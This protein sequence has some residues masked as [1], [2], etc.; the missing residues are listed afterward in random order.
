MTDNQTGVLPLVTAVDRIVI[1]VKN[2]DKAEAAYTRMFGRQPSWRRRDRAGGTGHVYYYLGNMGVELAAAIG[3]GV[4]GLHIEA[5]LA[6]H[7]EGISALALASD[8][9]ERTALLLNDAG[10]ATVVMPENEGAGEDG[11]IR[12]WRH[13]LIARDK[14]R[15]MTIFVCQNYKGQNQRPLAPLRHGVSE[16]AAIAAMDHVVVMTND[17]EACKTLFG[18]KFGIRLALDHSKPEWGVR[19]LFFRLGG[20]T[21][22]VVES[23]DK[24]KA[25]K[26]DFLWGTAWKCTDINA[27][28]A[29]MVA[30]GADVSEVRKGRKK[31]TE[32]ATIRPP[33]GGVPTL[34]IAEEPK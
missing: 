30:E 10:V 13:A 27:V 15:D 11:V 2:L 14:T 3:T 9:V 8:N 16:D 25:P 4:W 23:L 5:F 22:E 28:R 20:V 32:I 12:Y 29:R 21:I 7:G 18:D 17:A 33:T 19:Q 24:T 26:A 31:G 1:A 34:L 6:E